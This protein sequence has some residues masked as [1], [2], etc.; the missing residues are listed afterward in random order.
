MQLQQIVLYS[1]DKKKL[2]SFLSQLFEC[3]IELK[4]NGLR[5]NASGVKLL[6][7]DPPKKKKRAKQSLDTIL[8]YHCANIHELEQLKSKIEFIYYRLG[9]KKITALAMQKTEQG[10]FIEFYD[11]DGRLWHISAPM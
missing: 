6:L 9:E 10:F 8:D 2:A 11:P 5:I 7:Q 4:N 3:E 1:P